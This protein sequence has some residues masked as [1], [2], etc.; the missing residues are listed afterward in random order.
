[1]RKVLSK[2]LN[3]RNVVREAKRLFR[4]LQK[5][6]AYLSPIAVSCISKGR[7]LKPCQYGLYVPRNEFSKPIATLEKRYVK[8]F[9][10]HGW[11][12]ELEEHGKKLKLSDAGAK[13]Y[14]RHIAGDDAFREQHQMRAEQLRDIEGG[15]KRPL[16]INETE[17]PLGWLRKRKDRTGCPLINDYQFE[18]GE[19]LRSDFWHAQLSPRI[20]ANWSMTA[21]SKRQ[22]RAAP[23]EH[24]QITEHVI[25]AKKRIAKAIAAVGPELAG[26]LIDVC[27]HLE[28]LEAAEKMQGWPQR[29]GKVVLQLALTR[30]ARHYGLV[31]EAQIAQPIHKRISHWGAEDYKPTLEG[32]Q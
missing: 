11:L 24:V 21:N 4:K 3:E 2:Q 10:L 25:A 32:W 16:L 5:R 31:S 27:C 22:R 26:I 15:I 13:W 18:A 9:I 12:E 7:D 17:S 8:A 29:S 19:R 6:G 23:G 20:T 1:M 28:G 14:K 30:L